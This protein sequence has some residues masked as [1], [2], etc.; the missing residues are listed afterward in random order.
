MANIPR[1]LLRITTLNTQ[2]YFTGYLIIYNCKFPIKLLTYKRTR[3]SYRHND[4]V[5][6][7]VTSIDKG[8]RTDKNHELS[9]YD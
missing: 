3:R 2:I 6:I 1:E 7:L 9:Q 8:Y 5:I 4:P